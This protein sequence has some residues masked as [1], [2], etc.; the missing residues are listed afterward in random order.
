MSL[1]ANSTF[2]ASTRR[3]DRLGSVQSNGNQRKYLIHTPVGYSDS[4]KAMPL[5]LMLHG[6]LGNAWSAQ[7]D[8]G[9]TQKSD[10]DHFILVYPYGSSGVART[11]LT[12]NAGTCCGLA[13]KSKVDD[14]GFIRALISDVRSKYKIDSDRI[15]VAGI[16]NGGM[17][18]YRL[19]CELSDV[20]AAVA[21]VKGCQ[22]TRSCAPQSPVSVISFSGVKDDI[23]LYNGGTGTM[24]GYKVKCPPAAETLKFWATANQCN[25]AL[26]LED[27]ASVTKEAYLNEQNGAEVC[28]YTLKNEG[29]VW[30]GGRTPVPFF[31]DKSTGDISATDILCDFFWKHPKVRN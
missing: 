16:S 9:M 5:V 13:G 15:Y 4:G 10:A 12:W 25:K 18:A 31:A 11:L 29:H 6:A 24:L 14:V 23:I 2:G 20:I 8:S 30:P 19:G 26:P 7:F 21:S 3:N 17:M 28:L 22:M 27:S 1:S